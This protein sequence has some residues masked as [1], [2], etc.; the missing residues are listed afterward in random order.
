MKN[1]HRLETISQAFDFMGL[2][3]PKH[4]LVS[5]FYHEK[6]HSN[7]DLTGQTITSNFY[8]VVFKMNPA[9]S[10]GY[11]RNSYDFQEGTMLFLKP[12]QVMTLPDWE[13]NNS[14]GGWSLLFHPDFIRKS[15]LGKHIDEYSF[16]SY[17]V[18][19][20]LHLSDA[21]KKTLADLRDIIE[22]EYSLN[23]DK[24]SQ[25]LIISNIELMLDYCTRFYDRQF[26]TRENL[27]VDI[28]SKF[29]NLMKAYYASGK[30]IELG[31]PTVK[32]CGAELN[33]SANYLSDLLKKETGRNA[34]EYIQYFVIDKAKTKL[35]N[36]DETISQIAYSLGFEYPQYFS[37][38]FKKKTGLTPN[39]YRQFN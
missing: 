37:R 32:F 16:F 26:Y 5:V 6:M 3:K 10:F 33:M 25:K 11:G 20:A 9:S 2:D 17:D 21:E 14:N 27:N 39:Q 4:P 7:K 31:I 38:L 36:S 24:H 22:K 18:N 30:A 15:Q 28:V 34:Q 23:I 8:Q 19:E 29:E 1:I 13:F 12:G 35:L